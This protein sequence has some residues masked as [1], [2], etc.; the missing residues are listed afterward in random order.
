MPKSALSVNTP[1]SPLPVLPQDPALSNVIFF[2]L[3]WFICSIKGEERRVK[4]RFVD[5]YLDRGPGSVIETFSY[6]DYIL[7]F[8]TKM[9]S[10]AFCW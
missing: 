2:L 5:L 4:E 6:V 10:K 9:P 3:F 8:I 1:L 7:I